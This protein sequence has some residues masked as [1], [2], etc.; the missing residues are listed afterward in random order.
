MPVRA[1][2]GDPEDT[3]LYTN[4]GIALTRWEIIEGTFAAV[5]SRFM[6][7]GILEA[8]GRVYGTIGS[9]PGRIQALDAAS[10]VAFYHRKVN[11]DERATWKSLMNHYRE[12][13]NR[14]NEIAHGVVMEF[15]DRSD[16]AKFGGYYLAPLPHN[17][18][19]TQPV[20][21]AVM[22]QKEF[23]AYRYT[24][25]DIL[26]FTTKFGHLVDWVMEFSAAYSQKY[27]PKA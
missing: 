18:K 8:A 27:G 16:P 10:V 22:E 7:A 6:E 19:K 5:F 24:S 12:A 3:L 11:E 20:V 13:G 23:G 26:H 2:Q 4:V 1:K 15:G 14:R 25:D 21:I 17:T 9:V